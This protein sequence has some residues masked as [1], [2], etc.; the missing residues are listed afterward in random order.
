MLP[1]DSPIPRIGTQYAWLDKNFEFSFDFVFKFQN[2][3]L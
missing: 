2:V 1:L 3:T